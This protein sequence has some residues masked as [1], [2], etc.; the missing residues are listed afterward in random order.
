MVLPEYRKPQSQKGH[1]SILCNPVFSVFS[2]SMHFCVA[3]HGFSMHFAVFYSLCDPVFTE[4]FPVF[5]VMCC[6]VFSVMT[7]VLF[8]Y[9]AVKT[10]TM[11][12]RRSWRE[13]RETTR[14]HHKTCRV[15]KGKGNTCTDNTAQLQNIKNTWQHRQHTQGPG[16]TKNS[17]QYYS[18]AQEAGKI[19]CLTDDTGNT[20]KHREPS[21]TQRT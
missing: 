5:L 1:T 17:R 3:V 9:F 7:C 15:L 18:T 11:G 13:Q 2:L 6:A 19:Q 8:V 12:N 21:T 14:I 4:T 20:A 10:E 16:N